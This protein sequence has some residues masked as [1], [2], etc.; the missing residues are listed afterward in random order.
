MDPLMEAVKKLL[1]DSRTRQQKGSIRTPFGE[2]YP[3]FCANCGKD[4][5][6]TFASTEFMFYLCEGCDVHG[7]GLDLPVVSEDVI[8]QI[9]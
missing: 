5:G 1:P 2:A 4:C 8:G 3:V 6:Y 9:G 7:D